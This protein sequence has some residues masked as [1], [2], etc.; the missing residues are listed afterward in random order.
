MKP[1]PLILI[2]IAISATV[3]AVTVSLLSPPAV[4]GGSSPEG[5]SQSGLR[6]LRN[7]LE[8]QGELLRGLK[9]QLEMRSPQS[10][11]RTPVNDL[12]SMVRRVVGEQLV[13][14]GVDVDAAGEV[15][16]D[17]D[18]QSAL[19]DILAMRAAGGSYEELE[20]YW[21]KM[22]EEGRTE[23][24]VGVFEEYAEL[25]PGDPEAQML[26]GNAYL[27]RLQEA[28][29]GPEM[30]TWANKADEAFDVALEIDS[31]N[32]DARLS[33]AVS[34]SFWPPIFGKQGEAIN[35]FEVLLEKQKNSAPNESHA[36]TYKYLGNLYQQQGDSE[37]AK[38]IWQEGL[39][40]FPDDEALAEKFKTD[41]SNEH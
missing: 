36:Q 4:E 31:D 39:N 23:E 32:F 7:D 17:F 1:L 8:A 34:L 9:A 21:R 33:K 16:D 20:A 6:E 38:A 11:T 22:R 35:Q 14:A 2:A 12:E 29:T 28:P 27:Q 3:S 10:S 37:K 25:N 26:L 24:M 13:E 19:A 18:G 30:G 40:A 41:A 5:G 15:E